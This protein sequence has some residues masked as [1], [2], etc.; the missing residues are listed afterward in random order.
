[1]TGTRAMTATSGPGIALMQEA[2]SHAGSAEIPVVIVDCQRSG[3][4]TGMPTKPEQGDIGMLVS[5][6]TGDFPRIVLAPGDPADAFQL[7]ALATNLAEQFQGPVYLALD[8]IVS[9]DSATVDRFDLES[10]QI[11]RGKLLAGDGLADINEYRRYRVTDDG[12][13]PW[14]VPGTIGGQNLITGNER[15]EW[16]KVSTNPAN[17]VRMVDKRARKLGTLMEQLPAG[18]RWG[19]SEATVGVLGFGMQTGVMREAGERLQVQGVDVKGLQVRTLW[20]VPAETLD[21]IE[22][23]KRVYVIEQ[24]ASAQYRRLLAGASAPDVKL[25]SILRYDGLS[26]RPAELTARILDREG[27]VG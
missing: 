23:C 12:I 4:S 11:D 7:S 19:E 17:R 26:F 25:R 2:V 8:Q 20:P 9:Q 3:P 15:D 18:R 10:V 16:G 21:F 6:S 13:S 1:M 5:G 27:G 22:S 24:N 14:A